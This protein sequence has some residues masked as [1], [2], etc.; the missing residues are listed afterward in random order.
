MDGFD[1]PKLGYPVCMATPENRLRTAI[2]SVPGDDVLSSLSEVARAMAVPLGVEAVAIR[3]RATDEDRDFHLVAVDGASPREIAE[4]AFEPYTLAIVRSMMALG[5]AH[6]RARALGCRWVGGRWLTSGSEAIGAVNVGTRTDRTPTDAQDALF[7]EAAESLG[8][9]F[10]GVDRSTKTLSLWSATLAKDALAMP[11]DQPIPALE[12]LRP[13]E[14]TILALYAEGLSADEIARMLF[15][16][17]HT[18]RTHV[19]NA[20]RRLGVHSRTEAA[21][22]V[23][24]DEVARVV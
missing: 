11:G 9:A 3:L 15:I 2:A 18:V 21:D 5:T 23:R 17:P 22:L 20:F 1:T 6:S 8:R 10:E 12:D 24:R 19:K 4:R 7:T 16:S 13:R 14:R